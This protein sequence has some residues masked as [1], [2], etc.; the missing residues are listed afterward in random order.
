MNEPEWPNS[1]QW[2]FDAFKL[3]KEWRQK[4]PPTEKQMKIIQIK[5]S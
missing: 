4:N 2:F 1:K 5:D 3:E